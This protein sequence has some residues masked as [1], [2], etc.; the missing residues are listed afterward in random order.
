V[1]IPGSSETRSSS[2][3]ECWRHGLITWTPILLLLALL[4][5]TGLRAVDFGYHWDEA[6]SQV[7]PV[8]WSLEEQTLLPNYY[9][10]PSV[11]YGLNLA[12]LLPFLARSWLMGVRGDELMV[13]LLTA[14]NSPPFLIVLRSIRIA[15]VSLAPLWIYLAVLVWRRSRREALLTACVIGLSW[16]IAYHA[17]WVAPDAVVMQFGALTLLFAILAACRPQQARWRRL[18]AIGAA[19]ATGTKY[20]AGLLMLP[21]LISSICA[22]TDERSA[23]AAVRVTVEELLIFGGAFLLTTPGAVL[24]PWAFLRALSVERTWYSQGHWGYTIDAGLPH[25]ARMLEYV[26]LVLTSPFAPIA[27][28]LTVAAVAGAFWIWR[29]SRRMAALLVLFPLAYLGYFATQQV[30]IVRNLL[31]VAPFLAMLAGRGIVEAIGLIR[32][33]PGRWFAGGII[34]LALALNA[35][36]L[37]TTSQTIRTRLVD[38]PAAD[39]VAYLRAHSGEIFRLSPRVVDELGQAGEAVPI[40]TSPAGARPDFVAV[41]AYEAMPNLEWP[42]NIRDLTVRTFGPLE[43]NFDYYPTWEGNDRIVVMTFA[44]AC[45]AGVDFIEPICP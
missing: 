1:T 32:W 38:H 22:R 42:A 23:K 10:Y 37:V 19:L 27:A 5:W 43:V 30:M 24:Q 40:N 15:L 44:Q 20:T 3:I 31:V 21:V 8:R 12:G 45:G 2:S 34:A 33:A 18:A 4:L 16:E 7:N 26:G 28:V 41:Y 6:E 11:N 14:P 36:W 39:L 29:E 13:D 25:L 9:I 35:A 17:R